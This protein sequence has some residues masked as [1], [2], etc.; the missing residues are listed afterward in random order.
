MIKV[1]WNSP[2]FGN[3]EKD[4]LTKFKRIICSTMSFETFERLLYNNLNVH[5][6]K[7]TLLFKKQLVF[8]TGHSTHHALLDLIHQKRQS[9]FL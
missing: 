4:K 1:T 2:A 7:I 8:W 6:D 5:N 9:N 3:G